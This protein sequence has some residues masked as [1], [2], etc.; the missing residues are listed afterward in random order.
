MAVVW[1]SKT[2]ACTSHAVQRHNAQ[3]LSMFNKA[4][5]PPTPIWPVSSIKQGKL[6]ITQMEVGV[7]NVHL[8]EEFIMRYL[9]H[10]KMKRYDTPDN[11]RLFVY[12]FLAQR[13]VRCLYELELPSKASPEK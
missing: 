12:I 3:D 6:A 9:H 13:L 10:V 1:S 11:S 7:Q 8:R 4:P 5:H 2:F